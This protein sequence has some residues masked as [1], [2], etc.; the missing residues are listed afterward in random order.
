MASVAYA[1]DDRLSLEKTASALTFES[2]SLDS[3]AFESGRPKAEPASARERPPDGACGLDRCGL[4]DDDAVADGRKY[5]ETG[6][7]TRTRRSA[8]RRPTFPGSME[9]LESGRAEDQARRRTGAVDAEVDAG[10]IGHGR[11]RTAAIRSADARPTSRT[12]TPR[13]GR[14]RAMATSTSR[15]SASMGSS[16]RGSEAI[17]SRGVHAF[18]LGR[19]AQEG[20]GLGGPL[21]AQT[22]A[23]CRAPGSPIR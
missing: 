13:P 4:G 21:T 11:A 17:E 22:V 2:R 18:T 5:G 1:T 8:G 23:Q 12:R 7:R 20:T 15:R 16:A 10:A 3:S 9:D 19:S 14:R 6:G